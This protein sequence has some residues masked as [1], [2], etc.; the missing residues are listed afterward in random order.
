MRGDEKE[1]EHALNEY[2]NEVKSNFFSMGG[3][4]GKKQRGM[5]GELFVVSL[6]VISDTILK[7]IFDGHFSP[8]RPNFTGL[9]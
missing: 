8:S 9:H 5:D 2:F 6:G 3:S 7:K 1:V 4:K